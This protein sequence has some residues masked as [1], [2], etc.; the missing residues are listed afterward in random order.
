MFTFQTTGR[1]VALNAS[2]DNKTV[3]LRIQADN[4]PGVDLQADEKPDSLSIAVASG[5]LP[6]GVTFGT[7][8]TVEGGGCDAVKPWKNP[9]TGKLKD[10]NNLRLQARSVKLAK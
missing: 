1:V 8:I 3:F 5:E 10:I 2:H 7:R 9:T 4:V 6:A